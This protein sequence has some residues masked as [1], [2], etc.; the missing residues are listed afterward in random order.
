MTVLS[1]QLYIIIILERSFA[2]E[3]L[4]MALC[5]TGEDELTGQRQFPQLPSVIEEQ[6]VQMT[7]QLPP[8]VSNLDSV[9]KIDRWPSCPLPYLSY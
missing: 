5:K 7:D 3:L 8:V 4:K 1:H 2:F 6:H 9:N